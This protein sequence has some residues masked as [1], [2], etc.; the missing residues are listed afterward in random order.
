MKS[1]EPDLRGGQATGLKTFQPGRRTLN[2]VERSD[3]VFSRMSSE[4]DHRAEP[5]ATMSEGKTESW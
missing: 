5:R 4:A 2:G 1:R 3:K